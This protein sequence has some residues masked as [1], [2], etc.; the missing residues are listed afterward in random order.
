MPKINNIKIIII[1][2]KLSKRKNKKVKASRFTD[3]KLNSR[4]SV[5]WLSTVSFSQN[6]L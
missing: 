1:N 2:E 6:N 5:M 3:R 4:L